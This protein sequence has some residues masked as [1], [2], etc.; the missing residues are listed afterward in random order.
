MRYLF[1]GC[2]ESEVVDQITEHDG[3]A[4]TV[5]AEDAHSDTDLEAEASLTECQ[6][7]ALIAYKQ[8]GSILHAA[9]ILG[10][11]YDTTR[12][13]IRNVRDKLGVSSAKQLLLSLGAA[14]EAPNTQ[15]DEGKS[16]IN[17]STLM[18]LLESQDFRC[19]LTGQH[20]T[21]TEATLDHKVPVS[22]GGDHSIDNVWWVHSDANTAKGTMGV[23][24]FVAMCRRVASW[25]G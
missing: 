17:P 4:N 16:T 19:A 1:E 13:H 11:S 24:E 20:L 8:G 12:D 7:A 15:A 18:A 21:P 5:A 3:D 9:L 2:E 25:T 10:I 22:K 6:R 14:I 23:D